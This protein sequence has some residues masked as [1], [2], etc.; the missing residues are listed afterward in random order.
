MAVRLDPG[1]RD[2]I[3]GLRRVASGSLS[4][5]H[6]PG[7][8]SAKPEFVHL[9]TRW[10]GE[11]LFI[12]G[13]LD[14]FVL[15]SHFGE[16]PLVSHRAELLFAIKRAS[17]WRPSGNWA[18]PEWPVRTFGRRL[19]HRN[20]HQSVAFRAEC[21]RRRA[22]DRLNRVHASRKWPALREAVI[23]R[24]EPGPNGVGSSKVGMRLSGAKEKLS[25]GQVA[26]AFDITN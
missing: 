22:A 16:C 8:S 18:P 3:F 10:I 2:R 14:G 21:E 5:L 7:D 23:C 15:V 17:I 19:L 1:R 12:S 4:C 26:N 13:R 11:R 9:H 25:P 6:R 24:L 20:A